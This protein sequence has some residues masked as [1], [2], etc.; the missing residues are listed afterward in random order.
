MHANVKLSDAMG[1]ASKT[2]TNMNKIM[3]PQD[4]AQN[5]KQFEMASA[6]LDMSE[7]VS[8]YHFYF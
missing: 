4:V 7:E 8:K 5:M 2:M 6:K 3:N 1:T